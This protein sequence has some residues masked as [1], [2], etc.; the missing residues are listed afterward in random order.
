MSE[1][2]LMG[3]VEP[4]RKPGWLYAQHVEP[5]GHISRQQRQRWGLNG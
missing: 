2:R 5:R 1:R 4:K 3:V